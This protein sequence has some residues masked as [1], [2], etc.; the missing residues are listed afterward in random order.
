MTTTE[1]RS[2][3][4]DVLSRCSKHKSTVSDVDGTKRVVV[5][6]THIERVLIE[7]SNEEE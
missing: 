4:M 2:L 7:L 6:W 5:P 1:K 3:L